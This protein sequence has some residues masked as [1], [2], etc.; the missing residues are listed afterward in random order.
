MRPP[1]S[2]ACGT[3]GGGTRP[4][5][6]CTQR[7]A[8]RPGKR[9]RACPPRTGGNR[10]APPAPWR[11]DG[12]SCRNGRSDAPRGPKA[13]PAPRRRRPRLARL[14]AIP[15]SPA[16]GGRR[17]WKG[18]RSENRMPARRTT[19]PKSARRL[20]LDRTRAPQ[21]L[22]HRQSGRHGRAQAPS[23][24][25]GD[26]TQRVALCRRKRYSPVVARELARPFAA[27]VRF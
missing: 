16:R 2:A 6:L 12:A 21:N 25:H 13:P 3:S 27:G 22:G 23:A 1:P 10:R 4:S 24:A 7:R 5:P 19:G 11:A 20:R 18:A 17:S 26:R 14:R 15:K 8:G 9:L